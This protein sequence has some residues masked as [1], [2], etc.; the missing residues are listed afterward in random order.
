MTRRLIGVG[1]LIA[2]L[3]FGLGVYHA[4]GYLRGQR[5][6]VHRP[7]EVSAPSLP[8]TIYLV[9]N[10]AI[11][12]FQ[13]G[14][15]TQITSA[16]GWMQ[17]SPAPNNQLVAVRRQGNYSDLYLLSTATG[18]TVGQLTHDSSTRAVENNHWVFYPRLSRDGQTVFYAYDQ[19]DGFGSYR[20]DLA[21]FA[22]PLDPSG[23]ATVWTR[24]NEY[25]G[26]DVD[27]V[28]LGDG[29]LIY[30]KYSNDDSFQVHSQIWIQRRAG[31]PGVALTPVRLGCH[32][33]AVSP[34]EKLVAMVCNHGS[35]RTANLEM[36]ALDLQS[37]TLGS[38]ATLVSGQL[39]ASPAFSPD[40][41]T[42]AFLAPTT[43][44]GRFQLWTVGSSGPASVR[45]ITSDLG[46]DSD[47]APSW[48][49]G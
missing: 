47:S 9:Q 13:H 28:P 25:T 17:P 39:V 33:P 5:N 30:T 26:G 45:A 29:G 35:N 11:Y 6:V 42:I 27:P 41:K 8:G 1:L 3:A 49:A 22:T 32:E 18:K 38:A 36:A 4:A 37:L 24:P 7:T 34:D 21:I 44:G 15:F 19:K 16:S 12:R 2:M 43:S 48:V 10:G 31:S 46:F 23:R 20:V 40:G 14:N